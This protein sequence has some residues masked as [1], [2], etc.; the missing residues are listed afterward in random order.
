MA[1]FIA[2]LFLSF[3]VVCVAT[4]VACFFS[5]PYVLLRPMFLEVENRLYWREVQNGYAQVI[6]GCI[7]WGNIWL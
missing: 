4:P 7:E 3:T 1:E 5:T 6:R 2:R